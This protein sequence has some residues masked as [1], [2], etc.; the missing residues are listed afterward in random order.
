MHIFCVQLLLFLFLL[1]S[2]GRKYFI[3]YSVSKLSQ[4]SR[5][6]ITLPEQTLL[7]FGSLNLRVK[8]GGMM[9]QIGIK[10]PTAL[11]EEHTVLKMSK[12]K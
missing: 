5:L 1:I 3:V 7:Q 6:R 2:P 11:L 8:C 9:Q 12:V 10:Y 4:Y